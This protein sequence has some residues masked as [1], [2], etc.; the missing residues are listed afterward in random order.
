MS[1]EALK[2]EAAERAVEQA[3]SGMVLGLGSGST[4]RYA[5]M[6][7]G[8]LW[9]AGQLKDVVGIPTSEETAALAR[10]YDLPLGSLADYPMIDLAIDGA[11]EVDP[12]LNLIKGK[13]GALLREKIIVTAA[14]RFVVVVDDRKRVNQLGEDLLPVEVTTF[15]WQAHQ[16]WL[17]SFCSQTVLRL[18][19]GEPYL[20]DNHNLI[21]DCYFEGGIADS[22][23][24]AH[25]LSQRPGIVEHGLFLD[26]AHEVIIANNR[27]ISSQYR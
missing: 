17:E 4:A 8:E 6:K 16:R 26:M 23:E 21:I 27:G 25:T 18:K 15:A 24:L 1:I 20:T 2:K 11:D 7:I 10:M 14:R 9:Q 5:T 13:G 22:A 19:N 12:S 3:K